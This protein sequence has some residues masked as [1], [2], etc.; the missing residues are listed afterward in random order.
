MATDAN[1]QLIKALVD[2]HALE[3]QSIRLLEAARKVAGDSEIASI[4]RAHL[5]QTKEHERYVAE[6]L[7]AHGESPSRAKDAAMQAG[8]FGIGALVAAVPDTPVRLAATAFAF[9]NLEVA[10]YRLLHRLAKRAGDQDT[11]SVVERIL[12]QEEAAVELVEGTFDRA[13]DITLGVP[14]SSPLTPVTPIGK[15][16]ERDP[17]PGP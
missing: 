2:I 6:R 1:Q 15:P 17:T 3:K 4:Y 9:E 11:V 10:A 8:A 16:S 13:L 5:L 14:P 7:K 12:E